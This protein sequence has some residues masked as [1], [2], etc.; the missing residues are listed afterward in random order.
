MNR[1]RLPNL[2][3]ATV[4][5][6]ALLLAARP[7]AAYV[8][9][10]FTLGRVV[11]E[12]TV[13]VLMRVEKV[14]REK[15]LIVYR[16]VRDIKGAHPGDTIKH[17]IGKAGFHPR[18]WQ[19]TMAWA[20]VGKTALFFHNG[21]AGECCIDNY[22]Y[23]IYPGDWWAMSHAEP[24]LLRTFCGKPEKLAGLVEQMLKG[25]EVIAPCMVDGDKN[26]I[27]LRTAKVQRLK[28]SLKI[29]EY[30][31]KRDFAGW[32]VED[33]RVVQG[34]PGFTHYG[35][36]ARVDPAG[37]VA[38]ADVDG[39]GKTDFLLWGQGRVT[40]L[41]NAGGAFNEVSLPVAEGARAACWAD[42]DGDGKPDLLLACP[43]GP[44]LLMNEGELKFR[45]ASAALPAM[46]YWSLTAAA[47][48][49][50]DGDKRPDVLLADAFGGLRVW[51]NRGTQAPPKPP[52]I[53]L[54]AWKVCGPF[55][56]ADGRGVD[57]AYPPETEIKLD[58]KYKGK[59][60]Y[61]AVW[62][63][64]DFPEG[65]VQSVKVFRDDLHQFM[66]V[67]AHRTV[68]ASGPG[69]MAI[70]LGG[71]GPIKAWV[72]GQLVVAN[73]EA[74]SPAPDQVQAKVPLK[75]GKNDL[76][77]KY[78]YVAS[79]RSAYFKHT[80]PEAP[81][82][83]YFED[84]TESATALAA[85][86]AG[87]VHHL[88]VADVN[89]DGRADVLVGVGTGVLLLGGPNGLTVA[90]N[91]GFKY[92]PA[93]V[94]P[95][96][97]DVTGDGKPDLVVPQN[98]SIKVFA[99]GGNGTFADAS[100]KAGDAAKLAGNFTSVAIGDLGGK[101]KA[102]LLVGCLRGPNRVLRNKGDGSF[103]DATETV[104]LTQKVFNTRGVA[105]LDLNRDGVPDAV[106]ANEGQESNLLLSNPE[107]GVAAAAAR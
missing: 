99:G 6:A 10:P 42:V 3:A 72:N 38:P 46:P 50:V 82:V 74:R 107:R 49:D 25:Q 90:P 76:L 80:L 78:C 32:G 41:Q 4:A 73:K 105:L 18:E 12:S 20:E 61:E 22:W 35:A 97:G 13:I 91:P 40:L 34:M 39:D 62:K 95:A 45:D 88:L 17:N 51:R 21:S 29:M 102:D 30:D 70:S 31:A 44:K 57:T 19:N 98:G 23:Q 77:I 75:Q 67:Y 1:Y 101:G 66:V 52:K 65:Q 11:N 94:T 9:V 60:N 2:A 68:T 87:R 27:Q 63:D 104:G 33:I 79:G 81:P 93:G 92:D 5:L 36:L 58:A 24:Y 59:G 69:E 85:V 26:A 43:S 7:A 100:A 48:V 71:G 15:N 103:A 28:A 37:G 86:P 55:D 54:G 56:N 84:A 96:V 83:Q 53:E 16:K 47:F 106:F 89:G 14:D 8:E 64:F